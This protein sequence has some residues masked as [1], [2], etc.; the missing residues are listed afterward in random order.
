[1]WNSHT[2]FHLNITGKGNV[3]ASLHFCI[4]YWKQWNCLMCYLL[5]S[6]LKSILNDDLFEETSTQWV[7]LIQNICFNKSSLLFQLL[8]MKPYWNLWNYY[9]E[10]LYFL[11]TLKEPMQIIYKKECSL[12]EQAWVSNPAA[13]LH[14]LCAWLRPCT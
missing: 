3:P 6:L 10:T 13:G 11:S 14:K 9:I 12:M 4:V 7:L 5:F 8:A 2:L 1:M